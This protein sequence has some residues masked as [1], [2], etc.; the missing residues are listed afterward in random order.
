MQKLR[1]TTNFTK[2]CADAS[3]RYVLLAGRSLQDTSGLRA[4]HVHRP[5]FRL[6]LAGLFLACIL[7]VFGLS[8]ME[9]PSDGISGILERA[10]SSLRGTDML[11]T[12]F[13]VSLAEAREGEMRRPVKSLNARQSSGALLSNASSSDAEG[14]ILHAAGASTVQNRLSPE[15]EAELHALLDRQFQKEKRQTPKNLRERAV[16]ST[17]RALGFQ[18]G[19]RFQYERLLERVRAHNAEFSKIFDFRRLLIHDR[20]L[21]PVIYATGRATRIASGTLATEV[22]AT[23]TIVEP[24]RIVGNAPT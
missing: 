10:F 8:C 15:A 17:A 5:F 7:P 9:S 22:R 24:A 20:V 12:V 3:Y 4:W 14:H 6:V 1:Q 18:E 16:R 2:K 21:P 23:Y 11:H 19:C 13:G